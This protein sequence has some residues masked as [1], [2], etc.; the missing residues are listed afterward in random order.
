MKK[1]LI[2]AGL[3]ALTL[4]LLFGTHAP[5]YVKTAFTKVRHSAQGAVPIQF[6]IDEARQQVAALEPTIKGHIQ[7]LARADVEVD[8]LQEEILLTQANLDRQAKEMLALNEGLK[9]GRFQLT[10]GA[11][12]SAAEVR[13]ELASRLDTYRR[14]KETLQQKEETLK[15]KHQNVAAIKKALN[16]MATQKRALETQVEAIEAK[17]NQIEATQATNEFTFDTTPLSRAKKA[18][19]DLDKQL[20]IMA[21]QAE[22]EGQYVEQGI[23][24]E[25]TPTRDVSKEIDAEFA[26]PA[27][28]ADRF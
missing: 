22:Y 18:V 26:T 8:D 24:V 13:T 15:V 9:S 5:S 2:G 14:G 11:T 10:S 25:L 28:S 3:G 6:K 20:E 7:T 1:G 17:L 16:E 19:A 12:F 23:P 21:R 4:G 27:D